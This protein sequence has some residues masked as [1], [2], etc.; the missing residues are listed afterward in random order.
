MFRSPY[1]FFITIQQY[2]S[3]S[4]FII[5]PFFY[6]TLFITI[7]IGFVVI[8]AFTLYIQFCF[9]LHHPLAITFWGLHLHS[10]LNNIA[11]STM[12]VDH[13]P[14]ELCDLRR[15]TTEELR[16][17]TYDPCRGSVSR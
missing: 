5:S 15:S 17:V 10:I 9:D 13:P 12:R 16:A 14:E 6:I 7:V 4:T 8:F 2:H 1:F 3:Y 11:F